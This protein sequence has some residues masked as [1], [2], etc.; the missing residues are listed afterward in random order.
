MTLQARLDAAIDS[1][2]ARNT[3]VGT[4]ILVKQQ[5]A[6]VYA[7][8]AG[9]LDREAG[10]AMRED[11]IFRL[12]S[13]TKPMVAATI[14]SMIEKGMLSLDDSATD[15]LPFF[16]P[17]TADGVEQTVK[18]R[19]LLSH[20]S[21]M[22]YDQAAIKAADA[23][24]GMQGPLITLEENIRRLSTVPLKYVPGAGWEYST[25]IDVLGGIAA[26]LH[27]GSLGDAV[28]HYVSAPLGMRD[29][30]FHVVDSGRLAV[31]YGNDADGTVRMSDPHVQRNA[32][33]ETTT[34]SPGRIF[35][36]EAPQS[37]GAGM[38]G[39]AGDLLVFLETLRTGGAP[40]LKPE[41]VSMAFENQI[42]TLPRR[43]TDAGKR[44]GF[45][46]AV[47]DDPKAAKSPANRGTVDW[48]GAY[49]HNWF[50]DPVAGLSVVSYS[51][52]APNG[53]NGP[54][55]EEVRDAIYG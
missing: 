40:I 1:A 37:G 52:T 12:A 8:A 19:H 48:G 15:F 5:G 43:V 35:E 26:K 41:T 34:F 42:G 20:S 22:S 18:I 49:G 4:V 38:A 32:D 25:A 13:V 3:I 6:P 36:P 24:P 17:R 28:G 9:W 51:N 31:P 30:A 10:T 33:G 11:T 55:R 29:T 54:F 21:G 50:I 47:L 53:C 39:T 44:F 45:F 7:R 27:G 46:G 23:S 2:I 16:R 14:L